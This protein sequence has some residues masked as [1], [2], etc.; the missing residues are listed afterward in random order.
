MF[1]ALGDPARQRLLELLG[2]AGE[3]TATTLAGPLGMSRQAVAKHLAVLQAAG[4]VESSR[5][6][7]Q[8]LFSVRPEP[9]DRA[10]A[11][12]ADAAK[13]WDIRLAAIKRAA[14]R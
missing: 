6:G 10:A 8:V 4:L 9:L 3:A 11:W 5:V 13:L 12:L 7:K 14:E 1:A 2:T